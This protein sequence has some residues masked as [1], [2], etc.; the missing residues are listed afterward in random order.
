MESYAKLK[1]ALD[2][3]FG[4]GVGLVGLV[5]QFALVDGWFVM[6]CLSLSWSPILPFGFAGMM[7]RPMGDRKAKLHF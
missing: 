4:V 3:W 2:R 5:G 7:R 1:G 6:V